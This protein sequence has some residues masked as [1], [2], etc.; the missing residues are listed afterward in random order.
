M[1]EV[2]ELQ[3]KRA[4]NSIWNAARDYS[5]QP[6]FKAYDAEGQAELYLNCIIGAL[7]RHYDYA[8]IEGVFAAFS[9]EEDADTYEGLFW[10]GLENCTFQ[11]EVVER[12]VLAA[13]R[14]D[15]ARRFVQSFGGSVPDDYRLLDCLSYAHYLRVLGQEPHISRYDKALLDELEFSP[16]LSTEEIV[17]KAH[18]LFQRWFQINTE[19]RRRERRK[20][21]WVFKPKLRVRPRRYRKLFMGF[22]DHPNLSGK[23]PQ[24][25]EGEHELRT[26][27][28]AEE[29][30]EFMTAKYGKALYPPQQVREL[31]RQLCTGNHSRCHL[32]ITGGEPVPGRIQNGFEALQKQREAAQ[33]E[34]NR[35][36]YQDNLARSRAGIQKL[37]SAIQ[38]SVLLHLQ[39]A[40][41]RANTGRL[42]GGRVW[43]ATRLNDDKVFLRAGS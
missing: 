26:R 17:Q 11:R 27:M 31:E 29:L 30:R 35:R 42:L 6:D 4:V 28:T 9:Q 15:Y 22:V 41:V 32:H 12:P 2:T 36:Y 23:G 25:D 8:A 13:L 18:A 5:F 40:P 24:P 14:E 16:E 20:H 7:R 10:L 43:R 19:E 33:I 37:A 34:R 38:N 39:P 21:S 1:N 3:K